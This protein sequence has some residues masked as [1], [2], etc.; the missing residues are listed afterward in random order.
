VAINALFL[1]ADFK[2][3]VGM[4]MPHNLAGFSGGS[5]IVVPGLA[6][7]ETVE[8]NHRSTLRGLAGK[9]G[10][11][12]GNP[13]R[14]DIEEAAAMAGLDF[15][16]NSVHRADGQMVAL[17]CGDA[18]QAFR[19]AAAEAA[20]Y[21]ACD[22]P[23]Q[24]DV[25][26]F[27]AFPRDNWFLL[28]LSS[29]DVWSFRDPDRAVVRQGGSI[30]IINHCSEG[31]GEHGLHIKGMPHYVKRD[32]H[33][34]FRQILARRNLLFFSPNLNRGILDDYYAGKECRVALFQCW[35]DL[36]ADLLAHH[37]GPVRAAIFPC[38][39]LQMDRAVLGLPVAEAVA[40]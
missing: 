29:L 37:P 23:Y 12:E 24:C 11:V 40:R 38:G 19:R 3:G 9:I 18:V 16:L 22:V 13:V 8:S 25:G 26:V 21:Y 35:E 14:E 33:G 32:E 31:A 7:I 6:S 17:A 5:K 27:N 30:V 2:I 4:L 39:T 10:Q 15:I 36:L 20:A 28:S 1:E 34:T